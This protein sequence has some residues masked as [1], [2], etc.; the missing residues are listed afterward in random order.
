M[1][2]CLLLV[3]RGDHFIVALTNKYVVLDLVHTLVDVV[4]LVNH[5]DTRPESERGSMDEE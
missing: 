3:L 4:H 5:E 1:V 2:C